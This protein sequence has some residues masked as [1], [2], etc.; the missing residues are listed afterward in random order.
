MK[1]D[2]EIVEVKVVE[3]PGVRRRPIQPFE[4]LSLLPHDGLRIREQHAADEPDAPTLISSD[5][6]RALVGTGEG[7]A[8]V[9]SVRGITRPPSSRPPRDAR[10]RGA[11]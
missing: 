2:D 8:G 3:R 10:P 4:H 5:V 7:T 6:G 1:L 9:S 11:P